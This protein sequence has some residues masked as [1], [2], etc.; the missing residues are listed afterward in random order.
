[1]SVRFATLRK[2]LE[3]KNWSEVLEVFQDWPEEEEKRAAIEYA[4]H[5]LDSWPLEERVARKLAL[6]SQQTLLRHLNGGLK[7]ERSLLH[8]A[9]HIQMLTLPASRL[10]HFLPTLKRCP[11]IQTLRLTGPFLE[12][13]S[14]K[15]LPHL[16]SLQMEPYQRT[17]RGLE[18]LK[19]LKELVLRKGASI[20]FITA[21]RSLKSLQR[22]ECSAATF[23]SLEPLQHASE[24]RHLSIVRNENLTDIEA[25]QEMTEL[26]VLELRGATEL[27]SLEPLSRLK[28]L[29]ILDISECKHLRSLSPLRELPRL[30]VLRANKLK[31]L[32]SLA[33]IEALTSLEELDLS[34]S[35]VESIRGLRGL[36]QLKT[37]RLNRI[38]EALCPET[39]LALTK[40]ESLSI[41]N[42]PL[43]TE[44][45]DFSPLQ[46]L[47]SL[48]VSRTSLSHLRFLRGVPNLKT[49]VAKRCKRL[50]EYNPLDSTVSLIT[51]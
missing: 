24:M 6:G 28:K 13:E 16:Q 19:S 3:E 42:H 29:E 46:H 35:R 37:L 2:A 8:N 33:G 26:R 41:A 38:G 1:M 21:L 39:L 48:D 34:S 12:V 31:R 22:F 7:A 5:H 49:V 50:E 30:K 45:P 18:K 10:P 17:L 47:S 11:H 27:T 4:S 9:L 43:L 36:T 23:P 14:L 25:V 44:L 40:L 20:R 15:V 51:L 32:E